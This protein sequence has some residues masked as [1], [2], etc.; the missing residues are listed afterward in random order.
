MIKSQ[1]QQQRTPSRSLISTEKLVTNTIR[2]IKDRM[3]GKK[4]NII[5]LRRDK[6]QQFPNI[7]TEANPINNISDLFNK[8][9]FTSEKQPKTRQKSLK[10]HNPHIAIYSESKGSGNKLMENINRD[11]RQHSLRKSGNGG[12]VM[13]KIFMMNF[14]L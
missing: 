13:P 8:S 14:E 6:N 2:D 12:F 4:S 7:Q 9:Q 5:G 10:H 11:I 1:P 3:K